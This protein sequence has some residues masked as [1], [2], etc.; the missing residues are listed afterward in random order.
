MIH[1]KQYCGVP[2][3]SVFEAVAAVRDAI[4]Q[5]EILQK[6]LCVLS[7]DF[8]A[9]FD[10]MSHEY[11]YMA[12]EAHGLSAFFRQK[13]RRLYEHATSVILINGFRSDQIPIR[14]SVCQGY[15][16]SMILYVLCL[17][18]LIQSLERNLN[19]IKLGR[20]QSKT[21]VTAHADDVT[22]FLTSV[23][24]VPKLKDLLFPYDA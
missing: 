9:V 19:G 10:K 2:G 7:I 24:D 21:V 1:P 11:L 4:A 13:I 6:P 17:N 20:Y 15:P 12:L 16:L 14:N 8:S 23:E 22:I 3:N 18:P 5:A